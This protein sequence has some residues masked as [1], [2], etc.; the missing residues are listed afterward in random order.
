MLS[1][2]LTI[3]MVPAAP[4]APQTAQF[5]SC[6]WPHKCATEIVA[7]VAQ[8]QT[9][10]WPH[11]CVETPAAPEAVAQVQTCVWPHVCNAKS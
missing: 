2:I 9:C 3:A 10:V 11:V 4:V 5:Q 1:L 7:P 6:Q 8:V